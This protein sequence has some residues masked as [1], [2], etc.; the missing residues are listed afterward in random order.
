M[1][2]LKAA[3]PM[4]YNRFIEAPRLVCDTRGRIWA[5]LQIR[6]STGSAWLIIGLPMADGSIS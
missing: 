3:I 4:R 5:A 2:D 6:T 1:G